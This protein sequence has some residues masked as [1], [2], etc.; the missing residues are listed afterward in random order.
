ME[1]REIKIIITEDGSNSLYVPE[2]NETYHSFHGAINESEHVFIQKGLNFWCEKHSSQ[3]ISILEI[4][5]G[6][7]LNALLSLRQVLKT[8]LQINYTTLEPYPLDGV[9]VSKLNY[10]DLM[11]DNQLADFFGQ[12]HKAPWNE[13]FPISD[14]F[15]L[16]KQNKKLE[17]FEGKARAFDLIYFDAFAPN[18]QAELWTLESLQKAVEMLKEEG[19]LVTYCAKGQFKRDLK[20]A[21]MEVETL[22][23]PPGKK[24][25]VR[26]IKAKNQD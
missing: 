19:V 8:G 6:T 11:K 17:D 23:G 2:L 4:G 5:F 22:D 21:G 7:G 1:K 10:G 24:E 13:V 9:I 18:K 15:R 12:L 20:T 14:S 26:G 16:N 25:M 3:E